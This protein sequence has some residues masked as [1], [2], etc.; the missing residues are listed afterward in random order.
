[1]C[2]E[3]AFIACFVHYHL[4]EGSIIDSITSNLLSTGNFA[5]TRLNYIVP[6]FY[7]WLGSSLSWILLN[8]L[9]NLL[10]ALGVRGGMV[11]V[12]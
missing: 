1:M 5:S 11:Y 6:T 3:L 8:V 4:L 12:H 2:I 9:A 10:L 7:L